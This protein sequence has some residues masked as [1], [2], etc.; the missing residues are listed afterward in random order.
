MRPVKEE[1]QRGRSR[2]TDATELF[3]LALLALE[4]PLTRTGPDCHAAR[5]DRLRESA[6]LLVDAFIAARGGAP[7]SD[8]E[9]VPSL[10]RQPL[11]NPAS[12]GTLAAILELDTGRE[13]NPAR[14]D[15]LDTLEREYRAILPHLRSALLRE[16]PGYEGVLGLCGRATGS[17]VLRWT[18]GVVAAASIVLALAYHLAR[19]QYVLNLGGQVFWTGPSSSVFSEDRSKRFVVHVDDQAHRYSVPLGAPAEIGR[20]RIDPVNRVY[21]TEVDILAIHLADAAGNES[22]DLSAGDD[23]SWSCVNCRWLPRTEQVRRLRPLNDDPHIVGPPLAPFKAVRVDIAIRA[24]ARKTF[25]E[26]VTRLK[27]EQ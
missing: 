20:L 21:A 9:R 6:G 16:I 19:P 17:T 3:R 7:G 22:P 14:I 8:R 15:R 11:S 10:N 13:W 5:A 2:S 23:A 18:L 12:V 1:G 24:T 25:W 27:K 4:R 26:W